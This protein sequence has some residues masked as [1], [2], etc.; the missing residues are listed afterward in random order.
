VALRGVDGMSVLL[1]VSVNYDAL[2]YVGC[3]RD[4]AGVHRAMSTARKWDGAM[5]LDMCQQF[6][7]DSGTTF[8]GVEVWQ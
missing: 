8:F 2:Y 3:F 5:T 7:K 6:C 1:T 4:G